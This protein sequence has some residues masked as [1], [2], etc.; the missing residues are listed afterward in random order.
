[1]LEIQQAR[2]TFHAG[3]LNE[4]RALQG[5]DVKIDE[6]TFVV[7][8]GTNGSGKSTLLNAVA[9]TFLLDPRDRDDQLPGS[10]DRMR[11]TLTLRWTT[12]CTSH[13][14]RQTIMLR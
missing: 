6:G 8:I 1:M 10:S 9:G 2:K 5:V 3:T 11:Y 14:T 4:V 12:G 7:V 13:T